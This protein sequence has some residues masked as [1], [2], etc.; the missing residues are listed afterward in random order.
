MYVPDTS[1]TTAG[2]IAKI[3]DAKIDIVSSYFSRKN[4]Y[5]DS[6]VRGKKTKCIRLARMSLHKIIAI[7]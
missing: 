1:I 6:V 4:P 7:V 3:K 2:V 5:I